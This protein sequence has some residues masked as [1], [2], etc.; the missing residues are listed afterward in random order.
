M[1]TKTLLAPTRRASSVAVIQRHCTRTGTSQ[2][3]KWPL[4]QPTPCLLSDR[5][6][7]I[8]MA[9]RLIRTTILTP[10]DRSTINGDAHRHCVN[11][12]ATEPLHP[13]QLVTWVGL[14]SDY[15]DCAELRYKE[16]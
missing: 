13:W 4:Q 7:S 6:E 5:I 8:S 12:T 14:F 16:G 2:L 11:V 9:V 10:V 15:A 1:R 3:S